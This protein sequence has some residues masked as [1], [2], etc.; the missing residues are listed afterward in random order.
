[1]KRILIIDDDPAILRILEKRLAV[2]GF[3]VHKASDG[4]E[5]LA[6]TKAV[7]PDL[8]ITDVAM[9]NMDGHAYVKEVHAIEEF[10]RLPILVLTAKTHT[11]E[12]FS[13]D[14]IERFI[15][16][17]YD[18][19]ELL[20]A[21]E[22]C[23][24]KKQNV[25]QKCILVVDDEYDLVEIIGK[26]LELSGYEV[27]KSI[28]GRTALEKAVTEV[29]DL[30]II[31][32]MMPQI[33]GYNVCRLLKTSARTRSIPVIILTARDNKEDRKI[34]EE[35]GADLFMNKP[36]EIPELLRQIENLTRDGAL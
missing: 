13:V 28:N 22:E 31:D 35:V 30:I 2:S 21:I 4:V 11:R 17:P 18:A 24:M 32:V 36:F 9:P 8:V 5:G 14:D 25:P 10:R 26:R 33:D 12:M 6:A 23:L 20:K 7:R 3:E 27:L 15:P 16:K 1:M 19:E 34:A 29:P